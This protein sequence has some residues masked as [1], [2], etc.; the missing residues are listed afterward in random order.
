[1]LI[2]PGSNCE[3]HHKTLNKMI[4]NKKHG[5]T[6]FT[7]SYCTYSKYARNALSAL[8]IPYIG[9]DIDLNS[10]KELEK[11][12]IKKKYYEGNRLTVPQIFWGNI[13]F[14]GGFDKLPMHLWVNK[15]KIKKIFGIDLSKKKLEDA[16]NISM[17]YI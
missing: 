12:L 6:L 5:L 10:C 1:M 11:E 3:C 4:I 14:N 7:K 9:Y 17:N 13:Y 2:C 16:F 15:D 8:H